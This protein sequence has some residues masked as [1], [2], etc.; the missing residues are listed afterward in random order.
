MN[1]YEYDLR[2]GDIL[3]S[4]KE[5]IFLFKRTRAYW[6]YNLKG[7]EARISNTRLWGLIDTGKLSIG[8]GTDMKY[9]RKNKKSRTLDLHGVAH[10]DVPEALSRFLNFVKLPCKVITGDSEKMIEIV[11]KTVKKYNWRC[12]N[13]LMNHGMLHID[14]EE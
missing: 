10:S 3:Y 4:K 11:K 6:Y 14:S 1:F 13:D 12:Y 9:R 8:Y 2:I 5:V 7:F